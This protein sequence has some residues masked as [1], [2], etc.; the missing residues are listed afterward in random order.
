MIIL[1]LDKGVAQRL[2]EWKDIR[3]DQP[4]N[5]AGKELSLELRSREVVIELHKDKRKKMLEISDI[6]GSFG[7]WIDLTKDKFDKLKRITRGP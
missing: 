4:R 3:L 5:L 1:K 6:N 2:I 7:L